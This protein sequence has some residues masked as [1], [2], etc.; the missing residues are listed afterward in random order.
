MFVAALDAAT[1]RELPGFGARDVVPLLDVDGLRLALR[2]KRPG[3]P[4]GVADSTALAGRSIRLR[5]YFR[6]ATVFAVGAG[7]R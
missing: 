2:W 6:D 3:A 4:A 7:A 5:V 1:G